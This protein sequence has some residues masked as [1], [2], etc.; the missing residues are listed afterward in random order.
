MLHNDLFTKVFCKLIFIGFL[1]Y[2]Y[3]S[4]PVKIRIKI[5]K[6]ENKN[7]SSEYIPCSSQPFLAKY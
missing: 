4:S 1:F 5:L 2:F 6:K 3:F 7:D